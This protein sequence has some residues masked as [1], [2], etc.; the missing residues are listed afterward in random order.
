MSKKTLVQGKGDKK[1]DMYFL[2]SLMTQ[3]G[4]HTFFT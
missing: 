3:K 1:W 4:G 2:Q